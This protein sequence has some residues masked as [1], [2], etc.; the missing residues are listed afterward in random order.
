[1]LHVSKYK[2][3]KQRPVVPQLTV[4]CKLTMQIRS[5][6]GVINLQQL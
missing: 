1:M 4:S 5:V 3:I 6:N 2:F